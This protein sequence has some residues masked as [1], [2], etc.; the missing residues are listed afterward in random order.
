M[1]QEA[2]IKNFRK[3]K[4]LLVFLMFFM[5]FFANNHSVFAVT[6]ITKNQI[7]KIATFN[8]NQSSANQGGT[9]TENYY[10]FLD[11]NNHCSG[12]SY[13]RIVKR[14]DCSQVKKLSFSHRLSGPYY[15]WGSNSVALVNMGAKVSCVKLNGE[16]SKLTSSGC[17]APPGATIFHQGTQQG[18]TDYYKGYRYKVAGYTEAKIGVWGSSGQVGTWLVPQ[19]VVK[20][21]PEGISVDGATGE[22]YISYDIKRT[23]SHPR[24]IAFYK[25]DS[26][27]FKR[28]TGKNKTSTPKICNG[29]GNASDSDESSDFN[30]NA[31][32]EVDESIYKPHTQPY[33]E[34]HYDATIETTLFGNLKDDGK[35][36]GI[37]TTLNFIID[38]LTF[39]I[40][41]AA[42]IGI[43]LAGITYLT[44]GGN[45]Q[46]TLKA[47]RR[48]YEI[49]VGLTVYAALW[50]VLNW[51]LP[52]GKFDTSNRC[53]TI[54]NEELAQSRATRDAEIAKKAAE[55][56]AKAVVTKENNKTANT[57]N[58]KSVAEKLS[59]TAVQLAW[60][61]GEGKKAS[62]SA[63]V[64]FQ[65]AMKAT[66]T[67][68]GE[69]GCRKSG[70]ACG[71]FVGT[72]VRYAGVDKNFPTMASRIYPYVKK[73]KN[74]KQV[75]TK[76]PQPGD[77]S[78]SYFEGDTAGHVSI[79]VKNNKG[80]TVTAQA[81]LCDFYG[82]IESRAQYTGGS[83]KTYRY[84]GS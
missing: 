24:Q 48:I 42:T 18:V 63:T 26:S 75:S 9:V 80:K 52:G 38:I 2:H 23:K 33:S 31:T 10:V 12:K 78:L 20:G 79:Y 64:A 28:Y 72:V 47:K 15:K 22:V 44:A 70:K 11:C 83:N 58:A 77:I 27:V 81:S 67:N 55:E 5:L 14:D 76:N 53:E 62:K 29:V 71:M 66:G 25:I 59:N 45:T 39:G 82:I 6:K 61:V 16:K 1:Q 46:K 73:S 34:S 60:P 41:I 57:E 13:V 43:V 37:Y 68:K 4:L 50:A 54:S 65:R 3:L 49:I 56:Q 17:S 30:S 69:S 7:K 84:V 35:G 74:W 40:G 21:E 51:V 32:D 36:C 8:L 19:N